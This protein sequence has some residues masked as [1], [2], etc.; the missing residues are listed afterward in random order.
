MTSDNKV[1]AWM[2]KVLSNCPLHSDI[3]N[4]KLGAYARKVVKHGV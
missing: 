1:M 3:G 2:V 4:K